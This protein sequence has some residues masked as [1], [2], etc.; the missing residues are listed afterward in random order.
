MNIFFGSLGMPWTAPPPP[1]PGHLPQKSTVPKNFASSHNGV[2]V[3]RWGLGP[4][5]WSPRG[6][7]DRLLVT[8][9]PGGWGTVARSA[10]TVRL[11]VG[12]GG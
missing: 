11:S 1:L 8:V 2:V 5:A 12:A 9:P 3:E 7:G 10:G 6:S 4:G